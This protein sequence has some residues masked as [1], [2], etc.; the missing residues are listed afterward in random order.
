MTGA[1]SPLAVRASTWRSILCRPCKSMGG[2]AGAGPHDVDASA[3]DGAHPA[4]GSGSAGHHLDGDTVESVSSGQPASTSAYGP[5]ASL[6]MKTRL[7]PGSAVATSA[8]S[9]RAIEELLPTLPREVGGASSSVVTRGALWANL[10]LTPPPRA[11]LK[12][13]VQ[14]QDAEAAKALGAL[15][16]GTLTLLGKM[17]AGKVAGMDAVLA[18][19]TVADLE[20]TS[21]A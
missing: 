5:S 21:G 17:A 16:D 14:S 19:E 6:V 8:D 7:P 3:A 18:R 4:F 2:S 1:F 12:L 20:D 13:V 15:L 10:A 11:S 9:R